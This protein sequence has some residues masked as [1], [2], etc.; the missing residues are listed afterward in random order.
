[1]GREEYT[2]VTVEECMGYYDTLLERDPEGLQ[3]LMVKIGLS[4]RDEYETMVHDTLDKLIYCKDLDSNGLP[5][6]KEEE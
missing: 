6:T 5:I 3:K 4:N 1:M 2:N